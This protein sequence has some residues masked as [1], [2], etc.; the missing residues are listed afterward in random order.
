MPDGTT[1]RYRVKISATLDPTLLQAVD[2]FVQESPRYSRSQVIE[3]ALQLWW[4][5]QLERQME[6]QYAVPSSDVTSDEWAAWRHIRRAAAT[7]SLGKG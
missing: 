2:R 7:R 4:K 6:A 5:Q 1:E 3:D